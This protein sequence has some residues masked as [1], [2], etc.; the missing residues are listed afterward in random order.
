MIGESSLQEKGR[1]TFRTDAGGDPL[2]HERTQRSLTRL[3]FV[4]CCALPTFLTLLVI[5]IQMTSW[6]HQRCMDAIERTLTQATGLV[7][8]IDDY[9]VISPSSTRL[10]QVRLLD[11]ETGVEVAKVRQ[12]DWMDEEGKTSIRM[13]QPEVQAASL[14]L[15]WRMIHDRFL[16]RPENL[17][18]TTRFAA[19]DLT[20]HSRT[21][22]LTLRDVDAWIEPD[23]ASGHGIQASIE[24]VLATSTPSS[25]DNQ[26][27]IQVTLRRRRDGEIPTTTWSVQTGDTALPCAAIADYLPGHWTDLGS[28]ATFS[29]AMAGVITT[30]DWQID[31]SG[32]SLHHLSLDRI[33]QQQAHRLSGTATL[34]LERCRLHP[35]QKV[36]D[37]S[38]SIH[39]NDGLIGRSLLHATRQHLG[40]SLGLPEGD[41]D[42]A[43]DSL[44]MRFSLNGPRMRLDGIC[45]QEIG[46][47]SVQVGVVLGIGGVPL[48]QTPNTDL[49][50]IRLMSVLAP[51]HS[52]VV[53]LAD[54]NQTLFGILLPPHRPMPDLRHPVIQSDPRMPNRPAPPRIRS[55]RRYEGG[56]L[57]GQR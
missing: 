41:E 28:E 14:R 9:Q 35:S 17:H 8:Q 53:P 52:V 30:E 39:A 56:P 6:Y 15:A 37:I 29:G 21:S 24:A 46:Y 40:F 36:V 31:L 32:A 25:A 51:S 22:P 12:V 1:T 38:G 33:F 42:I 34:K 26:T 45:R 19:N 48:A 4:L 10:K 27:P 43:Y 16:C 2:M 50:A 23:S 18:Q 11:P 7:V 54:Q 20:I 13:Q 47:K 5:L 3:V 44:A 55:V 49:Q 57:T